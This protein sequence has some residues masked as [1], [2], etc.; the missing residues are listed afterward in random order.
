[1]EVENHWWHLSAC[2][3]SLCLVGPAL[4]IFRDGFFGRVVGPTGARNLE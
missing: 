2:C 3:N 1:M 4:T